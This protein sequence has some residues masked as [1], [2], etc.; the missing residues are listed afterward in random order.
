MV[1]D[2]SEDQTE[3]VAKRYEGIRVIRNDR[4]LGKGESVRRGA[5][6]ASGAL[7]LVVDADSSTPIGEF[8]RFIAQADACDIVIA[9]RYLPQSRTIVKQALLRRLNSQVFRLLAGRLMGLR[10]SDSQCGFKLF[11]TEVVQA[12]FSS[13]FVG[14]L[15]FDVEILRRAKRL[16][17]RVQEMPVQWDHRQ[18]SKVNLLELAR[19]YWDLLRVWLRARSD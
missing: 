18:G 14:R 8:D 6:S 10:V 13:P 11:R 5:L 16:G 1:D 9:S 19:M 17:L 3:Q 15:S 2:G 4:N 7:V 12:I